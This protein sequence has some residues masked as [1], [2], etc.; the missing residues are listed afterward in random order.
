MGEV[1]RNDARTRSDLLQFLLSHPDYFDLKVRYIDINDTESGARREWMKSCFDNYAEYEFNMRPDILMSTSP[2]DYDVVIFSGEDSN[3]LANFMKANSAMMV[4][5]IKIS[6]CMK[7]TPKRR[8]KLITSGF[9]DSIDISR[10]HHNE[11]LARIFAIWSRYR[12]T[13]QFDRMD[14]ELNSALAR[15]SYQSKLPPK[16][17]AV[18]TRLLQSPDFSASYDSLRLAAS[19]DHSTITIEN[20]KVI[21]SGIRKLLKPGFRIISDRT[22]HYK[23]ELIR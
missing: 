3:R 17:R 13:I 6:I 16:Q 18:L 20:L 7:S 15:A 5:K 21:I 9:D 19:Y 22:S 23:L 4:N 12:Q 1:P 11:F 2:I 14:F 8:A 10:T